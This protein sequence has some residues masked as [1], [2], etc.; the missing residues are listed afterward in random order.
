MKNRVAAQTSR[1]KKKARMDELEIQLEQARRQIKQLQAE[2]AALRL[3]ACTECGKKV[4]SR[5]PQEFVPAAS[6]PELPLQKGREP[7][8]ETP[9]PAWCT[10]WALLLLLMACKH[11]LSSQQDLMVQQSPNTTTD[12]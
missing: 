7:R 4:S 3:G 6:K 2:N 5:G 8:L 1:D 11:H 10:A 12:R 9:L